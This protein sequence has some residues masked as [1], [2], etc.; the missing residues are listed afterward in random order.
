MEIR[1]ALPGDLEPALHVMAGAFGTP[2]QVPSVHTLVA[3]APGGHL[4]VAVEDEAVV[5]TAAAVSFGST[6]WL[7]GVTVAPAARGRGLGR[8]LTE[9]A[10]DALG[11]H[12]TVSLLA[13]P[14]GRPIYERLGF[15]PELDYQVFTAPEVRPP[16]RPDGL[17]PASR[18]LVVALDRE[19]TGEDRTLALEA[20]LEGASAT[21]DGAGVVLRPPWSARPILARDPAAGAALLAATLEPGLRLAVPGVNAPAMAALSAVSRPQ[22]GAVRMRRGAPIAW[23]PEWVWGVFALFFG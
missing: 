2:F 9:A 3:G 22:R 13:T 21:P 14:A 8:V 4:L 12:E 11:E 15:V 1:R 17:V 23:R 20:G 18:D 5:G 16:A 19:A 6:G 7:G 10:L